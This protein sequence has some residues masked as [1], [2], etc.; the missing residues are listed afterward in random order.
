MYILYT[1]YI[2]VG[3]SS[4][5]ELS[6]IIKETSGVFFSDIQRVYT[7]DECKLERRFYTL[8]YSTY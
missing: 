3:K 6:K 2:I 5:M 7:Y 1:I 8:K 4:K